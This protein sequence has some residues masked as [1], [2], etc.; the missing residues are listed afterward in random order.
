MSMLHCDVPCLLHRIHYCK[1][2]DSYLS[3]SNQQKCGEHVLVSHFSLY[4]PTYWEKSKVVFIQ[5]MNCCCYL[6]RPDAII[7]IIDNINTIKALWGR[8]LYIYYN[9]QLCIGEVN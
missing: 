5:I 3:R 4:S 2:Y 7:I 9:A 6:A 1:F 8:L